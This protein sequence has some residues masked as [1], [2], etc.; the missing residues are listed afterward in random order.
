M[1]PPTSW[2]NHL[3]KLVQMLLHSEELWGM[4][5]GPPLD[6]PHTFGLV[7]T[8]QAPADPPGAPE[9]PSPSAPQTPLRAL[10]TLRDKIAFRRQNASKTRPFPCAVIRSKNCVRS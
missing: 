7:R 10:Q 9:A 8:D 2:G 3:L 6:G 4:L 5:G 1:S